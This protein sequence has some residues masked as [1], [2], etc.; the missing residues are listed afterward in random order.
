MS[1]SSRGL[2]A[3]GTPRGMSNARGR[4]VASRGPISRGGFGAAPGLATTTSR[5]A[6]VSRGDARTNGNARQSSKGNSVASTRGT[7]PERYE[8]L[9]RARKVERTQA[10][11]NGEIQD[12]DKPRALSEAIT[13][14]GKCMDMCAEYERVERVV[15]KD[16]WAEETD[17]NTSAYTTLDREPD[18]ARMVKKFRRSAAG[19]EEQLPSDLRPPPVLQKTCDYLFNEVIGNA[20]D[21]AKVHHF[22]WDRT[23]AIRNDFSIQQI[24]DA[25]GLRIAIDCY[26]RIARFHILSLHQLALPEPPYDKYDWQQEREQLDRTLLSLVQYYDD[27]RGKV[28]LVNEAEFRSYL[29]IFQLQDPIPDLEDRVQTWSPHIVQH[30]RVRKALRLYAAACNTKDLQG[31][32]KPGSAHVIAQQDWQRF[33]T[34]LQSPRTSYLTACV[35]E[36]YFNMI[37]SMALQGLLRS[38]NQR[39]LSG[40]YTVV[41]MISILAL[42]DVEELET[43]CGSFGINLTSQTG[44]ERYVDFSGLKGRQTLPNP[45]TALPKQTKT[46]LVEAKRFG[47]SFPAVINGM[48]VKDAQGA[49]LLIQGEDDMMGDIVDDSTANAR[50]AEEAEDGNAGDSLFMPETATHQTKRAPQ[51]QGFLNQNAPFGSTKAPATESQVSP[52]SFGQPATAAPVFGAPSTGSNLF[53]T[54]T[55]DSTMSGSKFNFLTPA[56]KETPD[57]APAATSNGFN[58]T[59]APAHPATAKPAAF[60]GF[61]F[62]SSVSPA[63][64]QKPSASTLFAGNNGA[65]TQNQPAPSFSF[66]QSTAKPSGPFVEEGADDTTTAPSSSPDPATPRPATSGFSF[67]QPAV[68]SPFSFAP[69]TPATG[70]KPL[71]TFDFA[72]PATA[73]STAHVPAAPEVPSNTP[74]A[75]LK[76]RESSLT[77]SPTLPSFDFKPTQPKLSTD[78]SPFPSAGRRSSGLDFSTKPSHPSPLAHSFTANSE[79]TASEVIPPTQQATVKISAPATQQSVTQPSTHQL[80]KAK[81][82]PDFDSLLTAVANELTLAWSYGFLDQYTNFVAGRVITDVQEKLHHER[83]TAEADEFRTK[84]SVLGRRSTTAGNGVDARGGSKRPTSSHGPGGSTFSSFSGH[85]RLKSTSHVDGNGRV[86]KP[87]LTPR[88]DPQQAAFLAS[89]SGPPPTVSTTRTNYFRLKA[90]GYSIAPGAAK[91][92]PALKRTHGQMSQSSLASTNKAP[93]ALGSIQSTPA[94]AERYLIRRPSTSSGKSAKINEEDEALFARL[95][96]ARERLNNPAPKTSD[97]ADQPASLGNSRGSLARYESPSLVKARADARLKLSQS[98]SPSEIPAY[99]LR[100]SKF[101]PREKYGKAFD[102]SKELRES[103]SREGS[104]PQSIAPSPYGASA[105]IATAAQP[106]RTNAYHAT[107]S[108][109]PASGDL[110][111]SLGVANG[112]P[113]KAIEQPNSFGDNKPLTA[114]QSFARPSL[115]TYVPP[116]SK[117]QLHAGILASQSAMPAIESSHSAVAPAIEQW[118]SQLDTDTVLPTSQTFPDNASM[119]SQVLDLEHGY[120]SFEPSFDKVGYED[121]TIQPSQIGNSLS[122]SFGPVNGYTQPDDSYKMQFAQSNGHKS[123]HSFVNTQHDDEDE[124]YSPHQADESAQSYG[125]ANP[126]ALLANGDDEDEEESGDDPDPVQSSAVP[127]SYQYTQQRSQYFDDD[128]PG[129]TEDDDVD[130]EDEVED[131][132]REEYDG[133]DEEGDSGDDESE[134]DDE[135]QYAQ[136]DPSF[137]RR[138]MPPPAQPDS[139]LKAVGHTESDAIELSD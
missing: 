133:S 57:S 33:W 13:P 38:S 12:P 52:F 11:Q 31:P 135:G 132:E 43:F 67:T 89:L 34:L 69:T 30:P 123:D 102:R 138:Q 81:A 24:S 59:A 60:G 27:S 3:R 7:W 124:G 131:E 136:Y 117:S 121:H 17:P 44:C 77:T 51:P 46:D 134:E 58:F 126:F 42:N 37:R 120:D 130:I 64:D 32:L 116:A 21:I 103:R 45:I 88:S 66:G 92:T 94:S 95:K 78:K 49:G 83:I 62:A 137:A 76:P 97:D 119:A 111:S 86:A 53:P 91:V 28:E 19:I 99:R 75:T 20:V 9:E 16:I 63:A 41:E 14:I 98:A 6:P 70:R 107:P 85:K 127:G 90:A 72:T 39:S 79:I 50:D 82:V 40:E 36:I 68:S 1:S 61:S 115:P 26:E 29:I 114:K 48:S 71:P 122:A 65:S 47:R 73:K 93:S 22:V 23:R 4:G 18:E 113:A 118:R 15:Q 129:D 5:A 101:V 104:R 139:V 106:S 56:A 74:D 55:T 54:K 80:V 108:R 112:Y 105:N 2:R 84:S 110:S 35:A 87:G 128:E 25:G 8:K 125:H 10:I 100:E 96:A 109:L